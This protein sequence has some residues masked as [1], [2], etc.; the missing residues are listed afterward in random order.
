MLSASV[1]PILGDHLPGM[2]NSFLVVSVLKIEVLC[3]YECAFSATLHRE[4]Q[5]ARAN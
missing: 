1:S 4:E 5:G 3:C 2:L